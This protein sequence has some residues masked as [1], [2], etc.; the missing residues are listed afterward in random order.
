VGRSLSFKYVHVKNFLSYSDVKMRLDNRGLVYV[1][2][3]NK[4]DGNKSNG[5]GKSTLFCDA[6]TWCLFGKL[7]RDIPVGKIPNRFSKGQ[8]SVEILFHIDD[9]QYLIRRTRRPDDPL[10]YEINGEDKARGDSRD[11]T[12]DIIT[13]LGMGFTEFINSILF[14]QNIQKYF[15]LLTDAKQK[16]MLDGII[17]IGDIMDKY[18]SAATTQRDK[19]IE[20]Q[21]RKTRQ[22]SEISNLIDLCRQRIQ[23]Y[24]EKGANYVK[25]EKERIDNA[26]GTISTHLT[27]IVTQIGQIKI[28]IDTIGDIVEYD[29]L[30]KKKAELYS[31][32]VKIDMLRREAQNLID[33]ALKPTQKSIPKKVGFGTWDDITVQ[34][35]VHDGKLILQNPSETRSYN[36]LIDDYNDLS[37]ELL[38][39]QASLQTKIETAKQHQNKLNS[40]ASMQNTDC[41]TCGRL[42]D[43][44][45]VH[46]VREAYNAM[47][48]FIQEEATSVKERL[49][50]IKEKMDSLKLALIDRENQKKFDQLQTAKV[51][52]SKY[53]SMYIVLEGQMKAFEDKL[54]ILQLKKTELEELNRKLAVLEN[55]IDTSKKR[56]EELRAERKK[57]DEEDPYQELKAKEI[58]NITSYEEQIKRTELEIDL[59]MQYTEAC[60]YWEKAF[61]DKDGIKA[62]IY[63]KVFPFLNARCNHYLSILS[64]NQI[65]AAIGLDTKGRF[66]VSTENRIGSDNYGG[67]SGG[68]KRRIDMSI[69]LALH[70]LVASRKHRSNILILDEIFDTLDVSGI[71]ATMTLLDDISQ[72]YDSIFVI[73]HT[74][75]EEYFDNRIHVLK[76]GNISTVVD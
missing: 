18:K 59:F 68:E 64:S 46:S 48:K 38:E 54:E 20:M 3:Q 51:D 30:S 63:D 66:I 16:D 74:N 12:N 75:F 33:E 57:A 71:D 21:E 61:G 19:S 15:F 69:M 67:N 40:V 25:Q 26:Y 39:L 2:G 37:N 34:L 11:T 4:D 32:I 28:R 47:V 49:D 14:G 29:T 73:S 43:D 56:Q 10:V 1:S 53:D 9:N 13:L 55:D 41:P 5:A 65:T 6:L 22:L 76:N 62:Y 23:D 42:V 60:R 50:I 44:T 45:C 70:D 7:I 17:D 35:Q 31:G 58:T 24:D 8:C 36:E 72:S 52:I 27:A